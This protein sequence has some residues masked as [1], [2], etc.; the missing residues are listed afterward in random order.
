MTPKKTDDNVTWSS[1]VQ[2]SVR[3]GLN[4]I[5]QKPVHFCTPQKWIVSLN[6]IRVEDWNTAILS[7]WGMPWTTAHHNRFV[8]LQPWTGSPC[9]EFPT[10][11]F[12]QPSNIAFK[13]KWPGSGKSA[14]ALLFKFPSDSMYHA[15]R[16][17]WQVCLATVRSNGFCNIIFCVKIVLHFV[18]YR[19]SKCQNTPPKFSYVLSKKIWWCVR[20]F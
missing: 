11:Q 6:N 12:G 3:N 7:L 17:T 8:F 10:T 9:T 5:A 2:I 13:S 16:W 1:L 19:F 15:D 18:L 14:P 20:A 4:S